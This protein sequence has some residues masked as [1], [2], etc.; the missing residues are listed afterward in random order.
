M[1]SGGI[2]KLARF[3][4]MLRLCVLSTSN[5]MVVLLSGLT[6]FSG[7]TFGYRKARTTNNKILSKLYTIPTP[8]YPRVKFYRVQS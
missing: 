6:D 2:L 8:T 3:Y 4:A 7:A 1:D 5:S